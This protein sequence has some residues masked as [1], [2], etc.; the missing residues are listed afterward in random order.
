ME[1]VYFDYKFYFIYLLQSLVKL[2]NFL[3]R[4]I[5]KSNEIN[6]SWEENLLILKLDRIG[7]S[8]WTVYFVRILKE[9]YPD[10]KITVIC[11]VYNR[12]VF[13]EN[14]NLFEKIISINDNPPWYIIKNFFKLFYIFDWIQTFLINKKLWKNLRYKW[15]DYILNFT[16]RK[17]FFVSKYLG[18]SVW[19]GLWMLNFIYDYPL[20]WHNE[21]WSNIHVVNKWLNVF[22]VKNISKSKILESNILNNYLNWKLSIEDWRLNKVLFF[23]WWKWPNKL[24]ENINEKIICILKKHWFV[25]NILTDDDKQKKYNFVL[26]KNDN[27]LYVKDKS[28]KE[29]VHDFDLFV[30]ID[31]WILHYISQFIPTLSFYT[32]TNISAAYPFW[33]EIESVES[34]WQWKIYISQV[35][36]HCIVSKKLDCQWCFQVGCLLKKCWNFI[37]NEIEI[38]INRSIY[39]LLCSN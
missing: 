3:Q 7:D 17:Y 1:K 8:V 32:S 15:F 35:W 33:G 29:F 14:R 25:T 27:W 34:I 5:I 18:K 19:N 21:I 28:L 2:S 9:K 38:I 11:N 13:E 39:A 26:T 24:S 12:F 6:L 37:D 30:W 10:I 20:I 22:G 16:G 31:W 4:K 36:K 23:V